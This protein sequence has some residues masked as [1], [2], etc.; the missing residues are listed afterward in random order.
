MDKLPDRGVVAV[1]KWRRPRNT[2]TLQTFITYIHTYL[3]IQTVALC[4]KWVN[5]IHNKWSSINTNKKQIGKAEAQGTS[6]ERVQRGEVQGNC[7]NI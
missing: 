3:Q 4:R 2:R 1:K 5:H 7:D 6:S